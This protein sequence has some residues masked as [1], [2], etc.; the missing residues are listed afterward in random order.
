MWQP[1]PGWRRLSGG[2]PSSVGLW[3]ARESGHDVVIKRLQAPAAQDRSDLSVP[4]NPAWWRREAD[5]ALDG[6]VSATRGLRAPR[7][8]Q[9]EEDGDGITVVCEA[10]QERHSSGL[11]LARALGE[12][13]GEPLTSRPWFAVDLL[14]TR[15]QHVAQRG[16]WHLL[17]RT[18]VADVAAHLWHRRESFLAQLDALP[19]VPSHGDPV[20]ANLLGR[21]EDG[22]VQ[23]VDWSAFGRG[24]VGAD[25]GYLTLGAREEFDPL[26]A[27][28]L[29]GLPPGVASPAQVLLGARISAVFTVLTRADWA[30]ARVDGGAGGLAGTHRHPHRH[31]SVVPHLQALQRQV[32]H[33]EALVG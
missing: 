13:A 26:V 28:Y 14:R 6:C 25:L 30:L 1:E 24:P 16:G 11:F 17:A 9:V 27:A 5:V 33:L 20:T 31:P 8:L 10:V 7:V 29:A 3:R 15:L 12:F 4:Q 2:G 19:R 23:A 21:T 22:A 32:P 18:S